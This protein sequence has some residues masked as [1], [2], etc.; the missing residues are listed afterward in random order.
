VR[1][2]VYLLTLGVG[3]LPKRSGLFC[4]QPVSQANANFLH[5]FH[6]TNAGG[7]IGTK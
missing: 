3:S 1:D 6:A 5:T 4:R 7:K 2:R